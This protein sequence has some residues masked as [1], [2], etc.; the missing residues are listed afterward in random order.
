MSYNPTGLDSTFKC[1]FLSSVCDENDV[2]FVS[3][4]EHMKFAANTDQYF[5]KKLPEFY[6]YVIPAHRSPGQDCG[7]AK[8]G[9]AQLARKGIKIKKERITRLISIV[10]KP[11]KLF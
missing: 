5:Q 11:I 2:D 8:A 6:Q 10:S 9:L 1:R 4:Q 3:I 7:R